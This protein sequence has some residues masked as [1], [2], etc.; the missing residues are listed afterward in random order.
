M[1]LLGAAAVLPSKERF[2]S[3]L[4]SR[5]AAVM[6]IGSL[7]LGAIP[8]V[9]CGSD[10]RREVASARPYPRRPIQLASAPPSGSPYGSPYG[11]GSKS[12]CAPTEPNI[13]GP[14]YRT[15]APQ[16]SDLRPARAEGTPLTIAG[17]VRSLD[18]R[19]ILGGAVLDVWHADA[20]GRYDNDG[21]LGGSAPLLYRGLVAVDD[22]GEFKIT[23]VVPGRYLNGRTYRPAHVHVK[24]TAPGH[25]PLT[26]QLYFPGDPFNADDPFIRPSLVMDLVTDRGAQ[27]GRYEFVLSPRA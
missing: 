8:L 22:R 4:A 18:C 12:S 9:G 27:T 1:R 20:H 10:R 3:D 15:G 11:S 24:V 6:G 13:E 23:T 14:Y 7:I 2:M 26:T 25:Q 5:R 17:C 16:R 21:H 19:S